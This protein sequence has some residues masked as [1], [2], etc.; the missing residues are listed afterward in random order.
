MATNTDTLHLRLQL[1]GLPAT[2]AAFK[3]IINS[4]GGMHKALLE[5]TG[6]ATVGILTQQAI[7]L[8]AALGRVQKV[9]GGTIGDI[10]GLSYA[11][12]QADID[13]GTLRQ[14]LK[15][16]SEYMVKSGEGSKSLKEA[17]LQQA[18]VFKSL[19]E[20]P[21]RA[22]RAIELFGGSCFQLVDL[23]RE[24]REELGKKVGRGGKLAG[25]TD[26]SVASA[27]AFTESLKDLKLA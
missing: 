23:V 21:I 27:K 2:E 13:L 6:A 15:T 10:A 25:F 8:Q 16:F 1:T 26:A 12:Q 18:D 14:G 22:E 24:G 17:L 4:V 19:P 20:G 11:G 9:V 3:S 5:L 7:E